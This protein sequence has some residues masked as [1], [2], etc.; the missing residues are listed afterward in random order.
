M[1]IH[2]IDPGCTRSALVVYDD[3]AMRCTQADIDY[4]DKILHRITERW[5]Q[6][7]SLA[8]EQ[9]RSYGMPVGAEVF[10]TVHWCGRFHQAWANSSAWRDETCP[11]P[12]CI[13]VPRKQIVT[14]LCGSARAKDAN[15][16]QAIL[17]RFGGKEKAIGRKKTPGPL[18][19]IKSHLWAALALALYVAD[20]PAS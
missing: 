13:L 16:R 9:V 19:G 17:D 5:M 8:I 2:A 7:G 10:D 11:A 20:D 15:V 12:D 6:A 3:I 14:H 4:N 1:L 18:Y